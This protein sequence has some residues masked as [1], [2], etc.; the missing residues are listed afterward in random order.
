[1]AEVDDAL[2]FAA[3]Q[4]DL[5]HVRILIGAAHFADGGVKVEAG[6][7]GG[8]A[9]LADFSADRDDLLDAGGRSEL[10]DDGRM[11]IDLRCD[12]GGFDLF[13]KEAGGEASGG[14]FGALAL[15]PFSTA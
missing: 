7:V 14:D 13:A 3:D 6:A 5:G 8:F 1:M 11:R 2:L 9:W 10:D 15:S 12:I 4:F